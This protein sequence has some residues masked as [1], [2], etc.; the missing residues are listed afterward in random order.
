MKRIIVLVA[1]VVGSVLSEAYI[2]HSQTRQGVVT[3][4][5]MVVTRTR[6][7]KE[8][9]PIE[10][11]WQNNVD[12][13][14]TEH[15]ELNYS[16]GWRFGN[17]LFLGFGTGIHAYMNVISWDK[18]DKIIVRD[19]NNYDG[20]FDPE[21]LEGCVVRGELKGNYQPKRI[22]VPLYA[23]VKF[24]FLKT[25]VSPYLSGSGGVIFHGDAS[26]SFESNGGYDSNYGRYNQT[27]YYYTGVTGSYYAK[28][29]IG[30]DVR[31][32]NKASISLGLGPLVS[33]QSVDY[34]S[35]YY[36]EDKAIGCISLTASF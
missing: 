31:L 7:K 5:S 21:K 18:S 33:G 20:P 24:R 26:K 11:K 2:A 36:Y 34:L 10:I 15:L 35:D 29:S 23:Q 16:G 14:V 28:A 22:G 13:T 17:F 32:K 3:T 12:V 30:I 4:S 9:K 6:V 1:I 27:E 19:Y 25:V 8:K